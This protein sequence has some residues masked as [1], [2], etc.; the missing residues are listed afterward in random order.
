MNLNRYK[1]GFASVL[2]AVT[3]AVFAQQEVNY[4]V[5]GA[6]TGSVVLGAQ[7]LEKDAQAGMLN[8]VKLN[9]NMPGDACKAFAM[10][11]EAQNNKETFLTHSDNL[12][13]A[14][15]ELKKD[16]LC[17]LPDFSKAT[18]VVTEIQGLYMVVPAALDAKKL[19]SEK[20]KIG[21]A[22]D[23]ALYRG[24]HGQLNQAFGTDHTFVG[25]NG[26][27]S[28]IKGLSSGEVDAMWQTWSSV[29][30]LQTA[31]P[32][33]FK[34]V[35]RTMR[36]QTMNDVTVIGEEFK[37]PALSRAFVSS[38]WVFND[39]NKLAERI[40][41][42]MKNLNDTGSGVYGEWTKKTN[43]IF[44]YD[45]NEQQKAIQSETWLKYR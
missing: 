24:W 9:L 26:S 30:Q 10:V 15:A 12:Y 38:F 23:N 8:G 19:R 13:T 29:V 39:R 27:G 32:G 45:L 43:K 21:Y 6:K 44:I 4:I 22:F 5:T 11:V 7:I 34:V 2:I 16:P 37:N 20:F 3:G 17:P 31:F 28:V 14:N 25:Y 35:Y 1:L 33:K 36:E 41:G 18:P 40:R 42:S